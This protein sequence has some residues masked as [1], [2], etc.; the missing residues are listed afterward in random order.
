[1][2]PYSN[3]PLRC[4]K[5]DP[6]AAVGIRAPAL[7]GDVGYDLFAAD[8]MRIRPGGV[9]WIKHN[10]AVQFPPGIWGLL[11]LRSS[12]TKRGLIQPAPGVI[13][14]GYRGPLFTAVHNPTAGA[15]YIA[16][17]D[18]T[19]QLILM[20]AITPELLPVDA[21]DASERGA[22]GFGSTGN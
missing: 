10:V 16:A 22:S 7:P 17:G 14:G 12:M 3:A 15:I 4:A 21:L 2:H 18:R 9:R 11:T 1:M 5:I 20:P 19:A 8:S 6:H 13:D